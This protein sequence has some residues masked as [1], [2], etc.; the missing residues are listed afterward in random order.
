LSSFDLELVLET[1]DLRIVADSSAEIPS[2]DEELLWQDPSGPLTISRADRGP[3]KIHCLRLGDEVAVDVL[4]G[5]E[6]AVSAAPGTPQSTIDHFLA[7]QVFPRVLSQKDALV[8]HAAAIGDSG[9]AFL[10][11]GSSGSGKSTLAASFQRCGESLMGD[12]AVIVAP[13][14]G[15]AT[16]RA[17]YPSLRL[18][19]DSIEA[20]FAAPVATSAMAHYSSKQ[21]IDVDANLEE[22]GTLPVKAMFVLGPD[23]AIGLRRL[24][25]AEACMAIIANSFALDPADAD[26]AAR[27]L[28]QA[29]RL[30]NQLPAFA[31][32]YPRQFESLP[33]VR[34]AI[35]GAVTDNLAL[36]LGA[37]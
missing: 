20:L 2:R 32:S 14:A 22:T 10:L 33:A 37:G 25:V 30:A 7:D 9:G 4:P 5:G 12:D 35:L 23:T 6:L 16:A 21:R 31:I 36:S 34:A 27:R 24:A 29:S 3:R 19:P 13:V 1:H 18:F 11:L 28:A 17:V 15:G 8:L 26:Q